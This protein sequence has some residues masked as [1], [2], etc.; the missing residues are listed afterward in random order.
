[1][2]RMR[3]TTKRARSPERDRLNRYNNQRC[4]SRNDDGHN[5]HNQV[6]AGYKRSTE[7]GA[8]RRTSGYRRRDDSGGE[9]SRN[10]DP[11]P[12]D[13]LNGPCN[14]THTSTGRGFAIT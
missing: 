10:F 3:T 8:D 11:S 12:E 7:E 1:M 2:E 9:R 4:R 5:P 14:I 6:A 13:M